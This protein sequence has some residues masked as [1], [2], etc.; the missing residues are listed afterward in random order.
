[1]EITDGPKT[2]EWNKYRRWYTEP[3]IKFRNI[4]YGDNRYILLVNSSKEAVTVQ[5]SEFPAGMRILDVVPNKWH[6]LDAVVTVTL[7]PN[8]V[9]MYK[10]E[11]L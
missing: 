9:R 3:S 2:F 7:E 5:L 8:G 6:S 10:I 4:Q 1:M 11:A